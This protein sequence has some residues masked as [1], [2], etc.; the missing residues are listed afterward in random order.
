MS[1]ERELL[2]CPFCGGRP[3]STPESRQ[4]R[5]AER[6]MCLD[7]NAELDGP[8]SIEQWNRRAQPPEQPG[9]GEREAFEAAFESVF[10]SACF[11]LDEEGNYSGRGLNGAWMGWQARASLK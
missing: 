4:T 10:F 3:H 2:P 7:C 5:I 9:D 8:G 1:D 11:E 6:V